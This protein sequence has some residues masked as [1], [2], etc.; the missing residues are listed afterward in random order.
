ML[1]KLMKDKSNSI[2]F[3]PVYLYKNIENTNIKNISIFLSKHFE[4]FYVSDEDLTTISNDLNIVK[5]EKI[6]KNNKFFGYIAIISDKKYF[7]NDFHWKWHFIFYKNKNL[8]VEGEES[9]LDNIIY[10]DTNN[11]FKYIT[12]KEIYKNIFKD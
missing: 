4:F 12:V 6:F 3:I 1:F 9:I 5:L 11:N 8:L 2:P 7:V 10:N